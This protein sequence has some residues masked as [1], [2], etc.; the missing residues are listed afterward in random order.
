MKRAVLPSL[1]AGAIAALVAVACGS[2]APP[3]N[4]V[5]AG[6][7]TGAGDTQLF[8]SGGQQL[9][10]DKCV[11][12]KTDPTH[13]GGCDNVCL[14][15][16]LCCAGRCVKSPACTFAVTEVNPARGN[17]SGG[18][19]VTLKGAGFTADMAVFIGDGRAPTRMIDASNAIIQ[20]PPGTIGIYDIT[21]V[22]GSGTSVLRNGFTYVAAGLKLPWQ[23]KKMSTV[24]GEHPGIAVHAGRTRPRRRRDASSRRSP[25]RP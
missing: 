10:V 25:R 18:D 1:L 17:Q 20:T 9:C 2:D 3:S 12:F 16:D 23:T 4:F 5:D 19:W 7:D 24:R 14:G 15:G 8:C 6:T 13:C 22:S 21:I 11:D